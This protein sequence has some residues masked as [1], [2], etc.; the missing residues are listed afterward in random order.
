MKQD[1][2]N[3][4][5]F[6]RPQKH[7]LQNVS[8]QVSQADELMNFLLANMPQKNRNN[9]KTLL[10]DKQVIVDGKIVT[11]YNHPLIAG[12]KIEI[13]N[14]ETL[15]SKS[16]K[17]ISIVYEDDQIVVIDKH[18]GLLSVAAPNKETPTAYNML[19]YHVKQEDPAN[20]IFIVH[21]LDRDTSGL[22]VYAKN[23]DVQKTL[24]ENWSS[25]LIERTY[26][27]IVEGHVEKQE[28]EIRSYL[29]ESKALKVHTTKDKTQGKLAITRYQKIKSKNNYS[30]LKVNLETGRKNQIRV[31]MGEIG[32]P[33]AGDK[34][35]GAVSNP[36]GR[37]ALHA[38]VLSFIHPVTNEK[39]QFKTA[40][41]RKFDRLF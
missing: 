30:L 38:S 16:L 29:Y 23:Q 28:D 3:K 1:N 35:Y 33:I 27:A 25:L 37:L 21:R 34:K 26:L 9:I 14:K 17:G 20:K 32:H 5:G 2:R 22:L 7:K 36:I 10:R 39:L 31:H 13:G 18:A 24:Q 6:G 11:Q 19:S 8:F 15:L 4:K 40:V 12:Q 41:P